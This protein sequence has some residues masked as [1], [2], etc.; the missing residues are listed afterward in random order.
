MHGV[1]RSKAAP[2]IVSHSHYRFLQVLPSGA[3]RA[4]LHGQITERKLV[5]ETRDK[6]FTGKTTIAG[7]VV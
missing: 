5:D 1:L 6:I 3:A 2:E 4:R 7:F